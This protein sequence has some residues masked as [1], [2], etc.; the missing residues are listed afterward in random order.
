MQWY[1]LSDTHERIAIS[2]AQIAPLAARGTLRPTTPVWKKGLSGWVPCGELLPQIFAAGVVRDSDERNP[3]LDSAAVRGT[4]SGIARTLAEY[5][6]WLRI[7]GSLLILGGLAALAATGYALV[8]H[9]FPKSAAPAAIAGLLPVL[10]EGM[11]LDGWLKV[12]LLTAG[13]LIA[14]WP[15]I[16]LLRTATLASRA[17]ASGEELLLNRAIRSVGRYA[18]VSVSLMLLSL[19]AL[20]S[21]VLYVGYDKAF[22]P[23]EPPAAKAVA[24]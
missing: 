20:L 12:S 17:A 23:P 21:W 15:G 24:I 1:Y 2:E 19:I 10:P 14:V 8:L 4:V 16:L 11:E 7:L 6:V 9:Y 5:H 3:V 13:A 22:P 18:V